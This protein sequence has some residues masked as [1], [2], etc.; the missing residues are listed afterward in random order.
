[1]GA[2]TMAMLRLVAAR[3]L[4][5]AL[6]RQAPRSGLR[7]L[8]SDGSDPDFARQSA[9]KGSDETQAFIKELV[10]KHPIL[11]FMK[12]SPENPRCG[13]S[14]QVVRILHAHK[15]SFDSADVLK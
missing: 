6:L 12:G 10:E 4:R 14:Q 13:F 1:M 15:V 7:A 5:P 2:K 11:L 3:T 9:V 8:S